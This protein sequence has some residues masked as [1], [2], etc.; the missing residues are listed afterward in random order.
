[1]KTYRKILVFMLVAAMFGFAMLG[2]SGCGNTNDVPPVNEEQET[3]GDNQ[4][5]NEID[6]SQYPII[7]NGKGVA[8]DSIIVGDSDFPTH[9]PLLP[10]AEALDAEVTIDNEINEITMEGLKGN[11]SFAVGSENFVVN[12]E[13]ITLTQP[14]VK[15]YGVIYVPILFFRDVFGAGNAAWI[16]GHVYIDTHAPGDMY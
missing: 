2:V 12:G 10:V 16:G 8:A 7:V 6:W 3:E 9:V 11:I 15:I 1:M 14:V 5:N 13:T 4:G